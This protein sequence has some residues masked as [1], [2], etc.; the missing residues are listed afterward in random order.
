LTVAQSYGIS[1]M[2][3]EKILFQVENIDDVQMEIVSLQEE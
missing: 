2:V 3:K 1:E